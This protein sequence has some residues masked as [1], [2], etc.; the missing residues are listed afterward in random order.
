MKI[1]VFGLGY[2]GTVSAACFADM[3][4]E[5]I[6]VDVAELKINMINSGLSPVR[7]DGLAERVAQAVQRGVLRA[8]QDSAQA[9]VGSD[10]SI[11]CVGTPGRQDGDVDY[12]H[13]EEVCC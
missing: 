2:V 12:S 1:S 11:I 5:V 6:G 10:I 8:T 4:H 3:G 7:E 13:V 9:V